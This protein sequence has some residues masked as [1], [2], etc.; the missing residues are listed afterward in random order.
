M[1]GRSGGSSNL[2][3]SVSCETKSCETTRCLLEWGVPSWGELWKSCS[4][5]IKWG[6]RE[7]R[8]VT[9]M[10]GRQS[11]DTSAPEFS[12]A[13][14][15]FEGRP[16]ISIRERRSEPWHAHERRQIKPEEIYE[17][18][19]QGTFNNSMKA[20]RKSKKKEKTRAKHMVD[21]WSGRTS[22]FKILKG[23]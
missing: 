21:L 13:A 17:L 23:E 3:I 14:L 22:L 15:Q 8:A 18:R 20:K 11:I 10:L 19:E 5:Q 1:K 2:M 12:P 4:G 9:L 6:I 16:V 7:G